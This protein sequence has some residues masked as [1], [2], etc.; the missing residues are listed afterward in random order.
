MSE[1]KHGI[2]YKLNN[3]IIFRFQNIKGQMALVYRN[4]DYKI[5]QVAS[6]YKNLKNTQKNDIFR[7]CDDRK[8]LKFAI[9][10]TRV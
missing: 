8:A 10:H 4:G 3:E 7:K 9:Y 6:G 5:D 1:Y 2:V